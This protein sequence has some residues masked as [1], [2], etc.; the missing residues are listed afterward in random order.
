MNNKLL[1]LAIFAAIAASVSPCMAQDGEIRAMMIKLGN[2]L[3]AEPLSPDYIPVSHRQK[4]RALSDNLRFDEEVWREVTERMAEKGFNMVVLALGEGVVYPSHPELAVNGSW[5]ADKLKE[6]LRRLRELGLE[7]IPKLNFSTTH[8][9][10]LKEYHRM[11]STAK[12]YEVCADLIR[13]VAELFDHPRFI[14]LGYDEEMPVAQEESAYIVVR[15]GELWWH[16]F[17]F[18]RREVEKHGARAWIW[19]D[20]LWHHRDEYLRRMPKSVLQSNWYYRTDFS[21][22]ICSRELMEGR[23][24]A[25]A[26]P[27]AVA[28][29]SAFIDLEEAGFDQIPCGSIWATERNMDALVPFCREHIGAARLKGFLMAPWLMTVARNREGLLKAVDIAG[30]AMG[31]LESSGCNRRENMKKY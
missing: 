20:Y 28:G 4:E 29:P 13:D 18:F 17:E 11:V 7:P 21:P 24:M 27:E 1:A 5:S 22:E 23:I 3:H 15:Q 30:E 2:N 16:D 31:G 19:S 26:W 10:W 14:H 6:E 25:S 12:Y 8:D 9:T